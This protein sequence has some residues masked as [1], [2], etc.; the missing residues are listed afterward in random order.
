MSPDFLPL[1]R[2]D[3]PT[4]ERENGLFKEKPSTK[5]IFPFSRGKNRISRGVENRGSL[6]SVPLALRQVTRADR[7]QSD[8]KSTQKWLR[9]S[10]FRVIFESHFWVILGWDLES[11]LSHFWDHFNSL[12][13]SVELGARPLHNSGIENFKQATQQGPCFGGE[14][15]RSSLKFSSLKIEHFQARWFFSRSGTGTEGGPLRAPQ[16]GS[17]C[18]Q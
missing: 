3:F 1:A 17:P 16:R 9:T 5:A 4:R 12:C 15:W 14:F 13:V 8:L 7:P 10:L 11:L 2:C 6:I 18:F